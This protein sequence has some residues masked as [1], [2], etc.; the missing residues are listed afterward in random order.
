MKALTALL[1]VAC[2]GVPTEIPPDAVLEFH[3]IPTADTPSIECT[4]R[5]EMST[6]T[7][8]FTCVD[9]GSTPESLETVS[10]TIEYIQRPDEAWLHLIAL[11][12]ERWHYPTYKGIAMA[13]SLRPDRQGEGWEGDALYYKR[14][15][16]FGHAD[17]RVTAHRV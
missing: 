5:I 13:I 11:P 9:S 17:F 2:S 1:A 6:M 4:G 10:T 7:A 16:L 15:E 8:S 12:Q 14:D 3:V